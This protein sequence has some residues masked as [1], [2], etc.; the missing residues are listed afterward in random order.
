MNSKAMHNITCGLYLLAS[1]GQRPGGCIINT[2]MQVTSQPLRVTITVNK[3]NHTH[4]LV[5]ASGV[6]TVSMLDTT[7]PFSLF[8]RFGFQSG[9]DVDK[10]DGVD[11]SYDANGV[12]YLTQHACGWLSC[13]VVSRMDLGTHTQFLADVVDCDVC[14]GG[15]PLS[16]AYYQANIKPRRE[17]K[18]A[19]GWVCTVC[20]YV[21]EGDELPAD[22]ICPICK[23]G[24]EAF[25][26]VGASRPEP[27]PAAKP[28]TWRC[29]LCGY[30]Y[31]GDE[32]PADYHCP[33]CRQGAEFFKKVE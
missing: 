7:A 16:Y 9:R 1:K 13:R 20:G 25:E 3:G 33:V 12:P 5:A 31:E 26:R 14:Q 8:Q 32:L 17:E 15:E 22:F 29:S 19:S 2:V 6:F 23:H 30:E 18:K 10:F 11:A 27:A 24:A 21:Y 4:D 28:A